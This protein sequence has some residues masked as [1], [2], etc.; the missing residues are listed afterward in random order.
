M[1][2]GF[3]IWWG[4]HLPFARV[5]KEEAARLKH[6]HIGV[7]HVFLAL[8]RPGSEGAHSLEGL[9]LSPQEVADAIRR[10]VGQ[11][12]GASSPP[13]PTPRLASIFEQVACNGSPG[14][15]PT[16][17]SMLKAVIAEGESLAIRYLASLGRSHRELMARIGGGSGSA[18]ET[19]LASSGDDPNATRF[20]TP[21]ESPGRVEPP[22]SARP[23]SALLRGSPGPSIAPQT[24]V[25]TSLPTPWL[26][27][28]GRDLSKL[29]RL[30]KLAEAVGREKE[31]EQMIIVLARTMKS[32][33]L[34][35]GEAG[36]GKT[37][38][39][40][41]L[42]WRISQGDVPSVLIG[43]RI[44]ELDMGSLTAGT[45]L[46]GQFEERLTG[47]VKE[48][49][50]A[51]EVIL[52]IDEVHTIVGAGDGQGA[53]DA[54]QLLKPAL[55]R[56]ELSCIGATTQDEFRKFIRQDPALERRFSPV[57]IRELTAEACIAVLEKVVPRIVSKHAARGQSL[58]VEPA[59]LREA[60]L[61]TD[62]HV[63]DRHQPD[64]CIDAIDIACAQAA[65]QNQRS[66]TVEDIANV[67]SEWT[68]IPARQ[69]TGEER[70]RLLGMDRA[71]SSRV[72][73]QEEAVTAVAR[74][75]RTALA[76]MK[77]PNRPVGVFLFLGPS[78]V[79]KTQMAKE[80][81]R[82]LFGTAEALIR[83]DMGEYQEKEKAWTLVGAARGYK[84][85]GEGGLLTEAIRRRPFSVV[86]LDEI[87]KAHPDIFNVFLA[88]FDDGRI[89]DGT[90]KVTDC[91]NAIFVLTSN[92]G[93]YGRDGAAVG[94]QAKAGEDAEAK[95]ERLRQRAASFLRPELV[96]R[97][98]EVVEFQPLKP[99]SLATVLDIVLAE[100]SQRLADE[101]IRAQLTESARRLLLDRGYD[102]A[103]G[104]RP[105][106]RA[107]ERLLVGPLADA[108]LAGQVGSGDIVVDAQG[109][110][111]SFEQAGGRT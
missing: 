87:E 14:A 106:E 12:L 32:N 74:R 55:A 39:V 92:L 111:L 54:A 30:G 99:A 3:P 47:I 65:V 102:P 35:L 49:S 23:P 95:Q 78:G 19:R 63:K 5:A 88:A 57:T 34:L 52:F 16:E 104:A 42:A 38:I 43:K 7:E 21:M 29:A 4:D 110:R 53:Q 1:T 37:A 62:R 83:I 15:A 28:F 58:T 76:G 70:Q 24:A 73:G 40:E 48:A 59:A 84:E 11:G 89:T 79:G 20:A 108:F 91:S 9:G 82:F 31:I 109:D 90:G 46:R 13:A 72:I 75:V 33:P 86:L 97:I 98:T 36:V 44:V 27:K 61:L 41:G 68:G 100:Q 93:A 80:L 45:T 85:S 25:P 22:A 69:L 26:D 103:M 81:A 94:F 51:P 96:N 6:G 107:V 50:N 56:G 18:D 67:V 77:A 8:V 66:V 105:L 71:L 101:G 60:V 10:Q 64:K 17:L 2:T